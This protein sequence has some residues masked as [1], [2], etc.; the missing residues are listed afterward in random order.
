MKTKIFLQF[1]IWAIAIIVG[2][3]TVVP[4][5]LVLAQSLPTGPQ[6]P[7]ND[8]RT[9]QQNDSINRA[10]NGQTSS[11]LNQAVNTTFNTALDSAKK[12]GGVACEAIISQAGSSGADSFISSLNAKNVGLIGGS[13]TEA[14]LN[15]TQSKIQRTAL[16]CIVGYVSRL[17]SVKTSNLKDADDLE[18]LQQN[19]SGIRDALSQRVDA[20]EAR[21]SA[22]WKEVLRAFMVKTILSI[23]KTLT[24][25]LVNKMIDKYKISDYLAYGD[26]L[27][28]QVYSMKYINEN[29]TGN[30]RQQM[31]IRSILQSQKIPSKMNNVIQIAN[32]QANEYIGQAC[33]VANPSLAQNDEMYFIRC[34]AGLGSNLGNKDY[35]ISQAV[36]QAGA[37][38]SVGKAMAAQEI[39]QSNG[40]APP[41]NCS[42]SLAQQQQID[43]AVDTASQAL[44]LEQSILAR[45]KD[46]APEERAK[47]QAKVDQAQANF[48]KTFEQLKNTGGNIATSGENKGKAQGGAI[49]DICEAIASPAN[50]VATSLG[51]FLKQHLEQ[52]TQLKSDNLPWYLNFLS[53]VTSNF[54]TNM[55]TGGKDK[56]QVLK[57][58]GVGA[59][60]GALIGAIQAGQNNGGTGGSTSNVTGDVEIFIREPN[61]NAK[62]TEL[63]ASR[64]YVLVINFKELLANSTNGRDPALNPY[65]ALLASTFG[66]S[67]EPLTPQELA[68]GVIALDIVAPA[69]G[70]AQVKIQF[71]ARGTQS[72]PGD[73]PINT[74][75][76]WT[77]SY[78]V[79]GTV[80]GA[81][82]V[83]S[84][85]TA[86]IM[87]RGPAISF[88]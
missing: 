57:E 85:T 73:V 61:G 50:F 45:L 10:I 20:T 15:T 11:L 18:R 87:P 13:E 24:T 7:V 54:L 79:T 33:N 5:N 2:F 81:T 67:N 86:A 78:T 74:S 62:L 48:N 32:A 22:G 56:A 71:F 68:A 14:T 28:S 21:A 17:N 25:E 55:L 43:T 23:N 30:T 69:S 58:A 59:L 46:A 70:T 38:F 49:I 4:A 29:F 9:H 26:A 6:V 16:D 53:D 64:P 42:G 41:R 47:A 19:Y 3:T 72:S 39:S 27:A 84:N 77:K 82:T 40:Y 34:V 76:G 83:N 37:A 80:R 65:R 63:V 35:Y 52:S 44:K 66:N 88:R 8:Q 1:S 12:G 51:D 31:M 36:D 75:G 60:N